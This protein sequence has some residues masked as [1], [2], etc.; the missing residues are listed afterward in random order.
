MRTTM[1]SMADNFSFVSYTISWKPCTLA[2]SLIKI[3]QFPNIIMY[4]HPHYN[5]LQKEK[6]KT[7]ANYSNTT[8]QKF[9]A[10]CAAEWATCFCTFGAAVAVSPPS[11]PAGLEPPCGGI[12][13]NLKFVEWLL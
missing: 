5:F 12:F 4:V 8:T 13:H 10:A 6:N 3:S 2:H 9:L 7:L 1:C 11:R